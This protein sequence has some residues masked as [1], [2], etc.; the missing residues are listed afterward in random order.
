MS[1]L[2]VGL[3]MLYGGLMYGLSIPRLFAAITRKTGKNFR[4]RPT[5]PEKSFS[6][7]SAGSNLSDFEYQ[8]YF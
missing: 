6:R 1:A 7:F 2:M 8:H 3:C 4:G 5:E